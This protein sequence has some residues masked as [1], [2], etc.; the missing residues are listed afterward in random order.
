MKKLDIIWIRGLMF[1]QSI[2][3]F[4]TS[5]AGTIWFVLLLSCPAET[6]LNASA[7]FDLGAHVDNKGLQ[8][9]IL[10]RP[11]SLKS[12]FILYI[13]GI[14]CSQLLQS[15]GDCNLGSMNL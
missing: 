14:E 9:A 7:T 5:T 10:L 15:W 4:Q 11:S 12:I 8:P 6:A 2:S 3:L 1:H 13:T